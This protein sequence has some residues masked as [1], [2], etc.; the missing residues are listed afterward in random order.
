MSDRPVIVIGAGGHAKVVISVLKA[1][2]AKIIGA[3]DSNPATHGSTILGI[4]VIGGDDKI[5]N[6]DPASIVLA[7]GIGSVRQP[8]RRAELF[9]LFSGKG[10]EFRTIIHPNCVISEGV[11]LGEGA[12]IMAGVILQPDAVIGR[13]V[14]VNTGATIDHDSVI[15]DH[16]HIAPGVTL[17]GNVTIG[18]G[19]HIGTGAKIIQGIAVG[20]DSLVR[21]GDVITKNIDEIE[22]SDD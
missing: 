19:S 11:T 22:K 8:G 15:G 12:Q 1:M 21:A 18:A 17:S 9:N 13:N 4:P 6:H 5:L 14:I 2:G 20:N 10:Y 3:V 7:N 16:V